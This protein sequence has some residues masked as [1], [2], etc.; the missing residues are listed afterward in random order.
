[1]REFGFVLQK[2]SAL[3]R[4]LSASHLAR[5]S[6]VDGGP[7]GWA[8][9][10]LAARGFPGQTVSARL[11]YRK[12]RVERVGFPL[13]CAGK[14]SQMSRGPD[15][16]RSGT[17]AR[18]ASISRSFAAAIVGRPSTLVVRAHQAARARSSAPRAR[19]TAAHASASAACAPLPPT[20]FLAVRPKRARYQTSAVS[21]SS[22]VNRA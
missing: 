6:A 19:T 15:C 12:S 9:R 20:G 5:G 11:L 18:L 21:S 3:R 1:M 13:R 16:H 4:T 7:V 10:P 2:L 17:S 14:P 8:P 22:L